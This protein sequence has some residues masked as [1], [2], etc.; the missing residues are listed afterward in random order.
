M[1]VRSPVFEKE[2]VSGPAAGGVLGKHDGLW[3]VPFVARLNIDRDL[4]V[5]FIQKAK[6]PPFRKQMILPPHQVRDFGLFDLQQLANLL[7]FQ[8]A[9][10]QKL[11]NRRA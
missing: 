4:A 11:T 5:K 1:P 2:A 8:A 6:Q 7:L 9:A 3:T 10:L